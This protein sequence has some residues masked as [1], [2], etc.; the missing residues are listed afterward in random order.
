MP[1]ARADEAR[2]LVPWLDLPASWTGT[3]EN[4]VVS[5]SPDD[6][7]FFDSLIL[8]VE[9]LSTSR[10]S[11]DDEYAQAIRDLGPWRP[12]GNP[13]EQRFDNGWVFRFGVGV[14]TLNGT[15]YTGEIA[16]AR[17]GNQRVRFWELADSDG[18]FN[19]YKDVVANAMSSAQDI[20]LKQA[21][22]VA[23]SNNQVPATQGSVGNFKL[24]PGFGKGLSGVYI[25]LER[26][27]SLH[28]GSGMGMQQTYNSST[29]RYEQS[30]T[31]AAPGLSSSIEDYTDINVFFPDG[32]YRHRL[33]DRGMGSDLRWDQQIRK[34]LWG[35]WKK[36][37]NKL[38]F[39]YSGYTAEYTI[40]KDGTL[41][42]DRDRPWTRLAI[43]AN[44]RLDGTFARADWRDADAPRLTLHADGRYEEHGNFL[45]MVGETSQLIVPDGY[46]MVDHWNQAQA[47]RAMGASSGTYTFDSYTLT[48]HTSDG[49][50][51]QIN[52]Y[53]PP[54]ES[55]KNPRKLVINGKE[56]LKD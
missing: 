28:A 11:L 27:L 25:G 50:V 31:T 47:D 4:G 3:V 6:L 44:T 24:D 15:Q 54:G 52:A 13:V 45:H 10:L 32:T 7:S 33:P 1:Q 2:Q 21:P 39:T 22:A 34:P 36:Q 23:A 42:S 40:G 51:W 12:V 17:H 30:M 55:M 9:P 26:G 19:R 35:T 14:A 56:L 37:G 5:L 43:P 38:I 41:I 8:M 20:T 16:V 53:I 48:F 49:R 18:T 46:T 29:G